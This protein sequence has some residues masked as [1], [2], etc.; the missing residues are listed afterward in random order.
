L[1]NKKGPKSL[2]FAFTKNYFLAEAAGAAGLAASAAFFSSFFAADAGAE[3][4]A[5][6]GAAAGAF[7]A[8]AAKTEVAATSAAMVRTCF[9]M[10]SPL[11]ETYKIFLVTYITPCRANLLTFRL[12]KL[13]TL[14]IC[15]VIYF[16]TTPFAFIQAPNT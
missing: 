7:G 12:P 9:I 5:A 4:L 13:K 8:S 1:P 3:A 2:L 6:A 11:C 16:K 10:R 14:D 15:N